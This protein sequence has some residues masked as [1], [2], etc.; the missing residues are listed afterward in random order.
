MAKFEMVPQAEAEIKS[1]TGK[2]AEVLSEYLGYI[3]KLET[4]QAGKL[5]ASEGE[6]I[7]AVRRRIG[8]AAKLAGKDMVIK[9]V[10]PEI[11]FWVKPDIGRTA[12]RRVRPRKI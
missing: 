10:G 3:E 5:E 12:R 8:A 6:T 9:R 7:G 1:A 4:G 2:R 11:Y